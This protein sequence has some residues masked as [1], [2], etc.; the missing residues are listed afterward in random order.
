MVKSLPAMQKT[1][2]APWVG[3]IPWRRAWQPTPVFLPAEARS[4]RTEEPGRPQ[5]MGSQSRTR[6]SDQHHTSLLSNT[7][8]TDHWYSWVCWVLLEAEADLVLGETAVYL[9][10]MKNKKGR[11]LNWVGKAFRPRCRPDP[12]ERDEG[13][14]SKCGR[15]SS[16]QE[17][18]RT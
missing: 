9:L 18:D 2:V 14:E 5:S 7:D 6:L 1:G 4:P 13:E 8:F 10:L 16:H 3:K 17:A 15:R 11:L 12:C